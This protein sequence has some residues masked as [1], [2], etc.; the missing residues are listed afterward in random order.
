[1]KNK[2]WL[3]SALSILLLG[4]GAA[5]IATNA[6]H[7]AA[8]TPVKQMVS[9]STEADKQDNDQE[10]ADDVEQAQLAQQATL[11]KEQS[12]AIALKQV[13]GSIVKTELEDE[14]GVIVYSVEV[15]DKQGRVHEVKVDAKDGKILKAEKDDAKQDHDKSGTDTDTET[16]HN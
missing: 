2:K 5:G 13:D 16:N 7:A 10:V 12:I 3:A 1:M 8:P 4:S 14:D 9:Q 11:T 15:K 6:V